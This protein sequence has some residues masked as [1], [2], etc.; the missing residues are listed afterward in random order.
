MEKSIYR[1]I[2]E[3]ITDG[4]LEDGFSLP[5]ENGS[6][7]P[8]RFAPGAFDGMCI[9]HFGHGA[10]DAETTEQM[11]VA[12]KA[13]ARGDFPE[14]DALFYEWTKGHRAVSYIDDI[15]NYVYGHAE[16][17]DP[18]NVHH[19]ALSMVLQSNHIECVKIG[20]ELLE[21]FGEPQ[22]NVKEI[23]RRLGLYD[24]FTIFSVWNMQ[25][26]KNGNQEIFSLAQKTHSWGRI[27]AVARLEPE[28]AEI[29]YWLLTE[30]TVNNVVNAYSSLT[31]WQKSGAESILFGHPKPDE[32]HGIITL[33][34]GLLDEGPVRGMSGLDNAESILLRFLEL[35]PEYVLTV[36][37]YDTI[38]SIR[39]W[40]ED[41]DV[42]LPSVVKAGDDILHSPACT[43][44][45]EKAVEEGSGLKLAEVLNI[46]FRDQLLS[47]MEREFDG[48]Y[49]NV[50]YLLEDPAYI[51]PVLKL[52]YE[53]LPL[54]TMKGD[55]IDDPCIGGEYKEYDQ[56]QFLIQELEDKTLTGIPFIKAALES[57]VSRN[58][59]RA[60][61]VLQ[62]WVQAEEC[63]LLEL[64]PEIYKEVLLLQ[65]REINEGNSRMIV[66]LLEGET[67]FSDEG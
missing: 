44:E 29:R 41:E 10:P 32:F 57:P 64:L 31:C 15:Q 55:P 39:E 26:W 11:A 18:G 35:A 50:S 8:L 48:S 53:K 27:H 3:H 2:L 7:S 5:D 1:Q 25:R 13:A 40:A 9:Y 46:P 22:E 42:D 58:R 4:V 67:Q 14:A 36:E 56:L 17:L 16:K 47:Y 65:K 45:I 66:P 21:L 37:D 24:E 19:T 54:D 28:T 6:R 33:I 12:L 59:H 52:F 61:T 38:L 63:A 43:A 51:E 62:A 60:L 20:L 30:G 34:E 23:I 49:H